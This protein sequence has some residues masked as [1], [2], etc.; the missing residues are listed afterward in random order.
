MDIRY[1]DDND[2]SNTKTKQRKEHEIEIEGL[3]VKFPFQP[4]DVQ[5]RF[6]TATIRAFQKVNHTHILIFYKNSKFR[7]NTG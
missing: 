6:M 7:S 1:D 3:M 2:A 4:Y 5:K